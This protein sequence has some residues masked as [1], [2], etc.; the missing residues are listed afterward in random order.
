[1]FGESRLSYIYLGIFSSEIL[2]DCVLSNQY[3]DCYDSKLLSIIENGKS[4]LVTK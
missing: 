4:E 1:M 2:L 3:V